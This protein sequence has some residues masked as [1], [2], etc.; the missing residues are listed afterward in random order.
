MRRAAR[1][2]ANQ[3]EIC[4]ALRRAGYFVRVLGLPVD[5]LVWRPGGYF[6]FLE[7]KTDSGKPTKVQETFFNESMGCRRFYVKSA[8]EA[9]RVCHEWC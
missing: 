2:D 8:D 1:V 3:Q 9:L 4:E 7:V 6:V 5:L